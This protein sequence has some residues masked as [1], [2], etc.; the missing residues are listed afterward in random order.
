MADPTGGGYQV[1]EV[2]KKDAKVDIHTEWRESVYQFLILAQERFRT[3]M[4]AEA[5]VRQ[6]MLED[7]KFR[8]SEQWPDHVKS[9][10]EQD[11][12]P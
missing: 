12:R 6:R 5:T 7:L 9:L 8:A 1:V 10:R 3:I 11:N 2:E 4:D